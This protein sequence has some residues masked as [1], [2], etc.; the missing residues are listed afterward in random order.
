[1]FGMTRRELDVL[2]AVVERLSNAEVAAKLFISERTVEA[3]VS[4]LFRKLTA[5]NGAE[6]TIGSTHVAARVVPV[7]S[8][9]P[10]PM[11]VMMTQ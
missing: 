11:V 2:D 9:P 4:S 1:M 6:L 10:P 8:E 5:R 3:H 7:K